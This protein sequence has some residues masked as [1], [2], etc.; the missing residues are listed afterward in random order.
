L[1]QIEQGPKAELPEY[2]KNLQ[3]EKFEVGMLT[4]LFED[5]KSGYLHMS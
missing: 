5:V 1:L 3:C 4:Y 2:W